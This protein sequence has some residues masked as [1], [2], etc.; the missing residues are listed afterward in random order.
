MNQEQQDAIEVLKKFIRT[1]QYKDTVRDKVESENKK[2]KA[3][4]SSI[5]PSAVQYRQAYNL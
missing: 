3:I 1:E 4:E 5:K 2:F